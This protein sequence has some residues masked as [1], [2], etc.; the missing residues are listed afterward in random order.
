MWYFRSR[1][2]LLLLLMSILF[3]TCQKEC[4]PPSDNY[5]VVRM[6]NY[7]TRQLLTSG[8]FRITGIG[9][10]TMKYD[11]TFSF[12][13]YVLPLPL[14]NDTA[15]FV[16]DYFKNNVIKN[17]YIRFRYDR[18]IGIAGANCGAKVTYSNLIIDK[19]SNFDSTAVLNNFISTDSTKVNVALYIK[20]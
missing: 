6:Y 12:N 17:Y 1:A 4:V 20:P 5:L 16:I 19:S 9:A 7:T 2:L 11:T 15:S 3:C 10:G 18:K 8:R 14:Q 13:N